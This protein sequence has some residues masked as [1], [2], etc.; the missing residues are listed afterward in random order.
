MS[1]IEVILD[2]RRGDVINNWEFTGR[3]KY[4]KY[5]RRT[6]VY[7]EITYPDYYWGGSLLWRKRV[8]FTA[9]KWISD[10]GFYLQELPSI[11]IYECP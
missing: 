2:P 4:E 1:K 7:F 9:T 3:I 8:T 5:T 11:E 6:V 10:M